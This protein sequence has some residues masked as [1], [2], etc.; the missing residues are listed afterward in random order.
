MRSRVLAISLLLSLSLGTA[1]AD[2]AHEPAKGG[3]ERKVIMDAIRASGFSREKEV[4]FQVLYL[5]VHDGWAWADV[6][7]LDKRGKPLAEGGTVLLHRT[8]AR[9]Q[10]VN[11]DNVPED[12]KDP[13][14]RIEASP[15][16]VK[17]LRK[18]H[19]EVPLDIFPSRRK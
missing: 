14:G 8:S 4:V 19:P 17:N 1:R 9:W 12:P 5:R 18:L 6:T 10:V 3:V 7:P 15:G 11:I 16:Y 2:D 13:E